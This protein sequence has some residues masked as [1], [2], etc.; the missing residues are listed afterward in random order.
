ME[1]HGW[2]LFLA[3]DDFGKCFDVLLGFLVLQLGRLFPD[4]YDNTVVGKASSTESTG[5]LGYTVDLF[6]GEEVVDHHDL[7][8]WRGTL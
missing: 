7:H 6:T 4:R 1:R 2:V 5:V 8:L 3:R